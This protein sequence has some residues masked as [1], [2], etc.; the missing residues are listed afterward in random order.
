MSKYRLR[1]DFNTGYW[2][3]TA[4]FFGSFLLTVFADGVSFAQT[5]QPV[6]IPLKHVPSKDDPGDLDA[7]GIMIGVNG[8]TARLYQFDTGSDMFVGQMAQNLPERTAEADSKPSFYSYSDGT[9]G[10]WM[11]KIHF[12]R[13][14]YFHPDNLINPVVTISGDF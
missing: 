6:A 3:V 14:S 2:R 9:Y 7:L 11:R 12:K 13:I 5:E 1:R 4:W 8:E 10:Y